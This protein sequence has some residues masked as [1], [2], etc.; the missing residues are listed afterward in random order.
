V[1]AHQR[2]LRSVAQLDHDRL[3]E[4]RSNR[5]MLTVAPGD[6]EHRPYGRRVIAARDGEQYGG[7]ADRETI[8]PRIGALSARVAMIDERWRQMH[9]GSSGMSSGVQPPKTFAYRTASPGY[10]ILTERTRRGL[11]TLGSTLWIRLGDARRILTFEHGRE[12]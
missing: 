1:D 12:P 11:D 3:G 7:D 8:S 4:L 9:G 2:S 10:T 5:C 6:F